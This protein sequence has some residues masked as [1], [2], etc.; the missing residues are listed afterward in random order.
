[1]F[2]IGHFGCRESTLQLSSS[3]SGSSHLLAV[4]VFSAPLIHNTVKSNKLR[5]RYS[6]KKCENYS[7]HYANHLHVSEPSEC[8]LVGYV[9]VFL[10][11][12]RND[13]CRPERLAEL[14]YLKKLR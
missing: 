3:H 12:L 8:R 14:L 2:L 5:S 9:D 6:S 7:D 11:V 10:S 4:F 13:I 1:M